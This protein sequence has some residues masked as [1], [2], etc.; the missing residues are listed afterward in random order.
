MDKVIPARLKS[1]VFIYLDDLLIISKD[2]ETHINLLKEVAECLEKAMVHLKLILKRS[3]L[4]KRSQYQ[5]HQ[6]K[7]EV[8]WVLRDGT[9]VL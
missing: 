9:G 1:D 7:L 5:N 8:F 3:W 4:Y 6:E 2:F